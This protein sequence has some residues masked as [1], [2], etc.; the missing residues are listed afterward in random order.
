[1]ANRFKK[2][3]VDMNKSLD[4]KVVAYLRALKVP[5]VEKIIYISNIFFQDSSE[6]KEVESSEFL[7]LVTSYSMIEGN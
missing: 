3:A 2:M 1:M 7:F 6:K 4:Q 5:L